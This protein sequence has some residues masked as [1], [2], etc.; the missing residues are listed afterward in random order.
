MLET[1]VVVI[2][3]GA[4][5]LGVLRDLSMRGVGAILLEQGDVANGTSARF[6]GLLHS[7]GRYVVKD[8]DSARE[9]IAENAVLRRI[10]AHCV[11]ETEGFFV[12]VPEDD[13]AWER[14]WVDACRATGLQAVPIDPAEAV[15]LEPDLARDASAV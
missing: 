8:P 6:H 15:R 11:E 10:G 5:G 3:G 13:Q 12:R 7:G 4:T 14:R 1:T 2:G 9:C